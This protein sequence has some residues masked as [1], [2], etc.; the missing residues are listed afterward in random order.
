M[1]KVGSPL[2]VLLLFGAVCPILNG[3]ALVVGDCNLAGHDGEMALVGT[4]L[5]VQLPLRASPFN[6][7]HFCAQTSIL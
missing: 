7:Q 5:V 3:S 4:L 2:A 1:V 6:H